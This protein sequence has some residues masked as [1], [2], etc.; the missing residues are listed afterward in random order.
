MIKNSIGRKPINKFTAEDLEKAQKWEDIINSGQ[1]LGLQGN[2][3]NG[4]ISSDNINA[5]RS[6][7]NAGTNAELLEGRKVSTAGRS[8]NRIRTHGANTYIIRGELGDLQRRKGNDDIPMEGGETAW[9]SDPDFGP[10]QKMGSGLDESFLRN[11][12]GVKSNGFDSIGR[13]LSPEMAKSFYK[14]RYIKKHAA[15]T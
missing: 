4:I 8:K 5:D 12:Q 14:N 3:K 6:G 15:S 2:Q 9:L 13:K 10:A 11:I 1:K 7:D